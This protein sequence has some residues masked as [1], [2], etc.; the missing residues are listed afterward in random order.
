MSKNIN[1]LIDV[2]TT[3]LETKTYK[4]PADF[5]LNGKAEEIRKRTWFLID[6]RFSECF[7]AKSI[8]NKII[9][10]IILTTSVLLFPLTVPI[11]LIFMR[12]AA[13][14]QVNEEL[15]KERLELMNKTLNPTFENIDQKLEKRK[16]S[17]LKPKHIEKINYYAKR[18][19][20]SY[21]IHERLNCYMRDKNDTYTE[22]WKNIMSGHVRVDKNDK[23]LLTNRLFKMTSEISLNEVFVNLKNFL[24]RPNGYDFDKSRGLDDIT[25]VYDGQTFDKIQPSAVEDKLDDFAQHISTNEGINNL[26]QLK[27]LVRGLIARNSVISCLTGRMCPDQHKQLFNIVPDTASQTN[28]NL[29][30]LEY[31]DNKL[32]VIYVIEQGYQLNPGL[33]NESKIGTLTCPFRIEINNIPKAIHE[34]YKA[35]EEKQAPKDSQSKSL[36][37]DDVDNS[38]FMTVNVGQGRMK[39]ADHGHQPI[40]LNGKNEFVDNSSEPASPSSSSPSPTP[41]SS[42]TSANSPS[43]GRSPLSSVSSDED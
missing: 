17:Y 31:K 12:S 30:N 34:L 25:L 4:L 23:T 16:K 14:K 42:D 15:A 43:P 19:K 22:K 8:P 2:W 7:H 9:N 35:E 29:V 40:R 41:N 26:D 3:P 39:W 20:E 28:N 10:A 27:N 38:S 13:K 1:S 18:S 36:V 33:P 6:R 24:D 11:G 32:T 37:S 5:T 21:P